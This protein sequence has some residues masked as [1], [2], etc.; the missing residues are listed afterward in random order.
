VCEALV[1]F[2]SNEKPG[3]FLST[4]ESSMGEVDWGLRAETRECAECQGGAAGSQDNNVMERGRARR[5]L[6]LEV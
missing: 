6:K 5:T 2:F 1:L 4:I 3:I